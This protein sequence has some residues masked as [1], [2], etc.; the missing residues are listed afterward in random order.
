MAS[1][2]IYHVLEGLVPEEVLALLPHRLEVS[3]SSHSWYTCAN[4]HLM[5][6]QDKPRRK[7]DYDCAHSTD[8]KRKSA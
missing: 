5:K 6:P 7:M 8:E 1:F 3:D 2:N 4:P